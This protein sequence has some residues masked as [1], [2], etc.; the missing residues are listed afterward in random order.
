MSCMSRKLETVRHNADP[1]CPNSNKNSRDFP[2]VRGTL[3]LFAIDPAKQGFGVDF[4]EAHLIKGVSFSGKAGILGFDNAIENNWI[5][6][7]Q[8]AKAWLYPA[9]PINSTCIGQNIIGAALEDTNPPKHC[10]CTNYPSR[11]HTPMLGLYTTR[12][13]IIKKTSKEVTRNYKFT[14]QG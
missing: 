10:C 11:P 13:I 3:F 6:S 1:T 5:I 12:Y 9:D 7:R 2:V 8:I 14:T 4:R